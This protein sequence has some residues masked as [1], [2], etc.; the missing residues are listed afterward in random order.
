VGGQAVPATPR[1]SFNPVDVTINTTQAVAIQ[2][3]GRNIPPGTS[4]T[5]IVANETEGSQTVSSSPLAGTAELSTANAT[6]TIPAGFSRIFS[7][8]T[9]Q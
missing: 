2:L 7:H 5:L 3:E 9:W 6:V 4:I 1:G 8:A